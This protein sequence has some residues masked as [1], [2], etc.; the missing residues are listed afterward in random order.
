MQQGKK[1]SGLF[2]LGGTAANARCSCISHITCNVQSPDLSLSIFLFLL[3][4][5]H[6]HALLYLNKRRRHLYKETKMDND[7]REARNPQ[8]LLFSLSLLPWKF[9]DRYLTFPCICL[10]L[11]K[12]A[13]CTSIHPPE[14][15]LIGS[16][17]SKW[18]FINAENWIALVNGC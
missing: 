4:F 15:L 10:F 16:L 1:K 18:L 5:H 12:R 17:G 7:K 14:K 6:G 3:C 13:L 11:T 8:K 2:G 9:K